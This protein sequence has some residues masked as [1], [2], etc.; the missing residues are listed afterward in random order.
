ML[1]WAPR[2]AHRPPPT[3]GRAWPRG[4][5]PAPRAGSHAL[6]P[7]PLPTGLAGSSFARAPPNRLCFAGDGRGLGCVCGGGSTDLAGWTSW[8]GEH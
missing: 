7:A 8:G 3:S 2:T 4:P 5:L 1:L 6:R